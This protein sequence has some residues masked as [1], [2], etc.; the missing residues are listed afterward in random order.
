M[1]SAK[2]TTPA[3]RFKGFVEE[4]EGRPLGDIAE[5]VT[6][7]DPNSTAPVMMITADNGFIKQSD[8]YAFNNSGQS[9]TKY[10]VLKREELAY[11]HGASKLRPYGSCFALPYKEARVPFVY[12]CFTVNNDNSDFIAIQL[13]GTSVEAELRKI[14]S[15][16]ARMDG[17][18]NISYEAYS[19]AP[20][21]LP[22]TDEQVA[23]AN[24]F[25]N[26]DNLI[27]LQRR[28]LVK[29]QN[30]KKAMLQKMFPT[31][32]S[33]TPQ[34]RFAGFTD[35][36]EER[37]L[38][39][40]CSIFTDGDWIESKDQ[41]D[42]G[43]RLI[44]TGNVGVAEFIDKPNNSKWISEETFERLHCK[45]V[46]PGDILI[47]RLPEPAGRACIIPNLG[48]KM[49]TAVDCTI[50]RTT[51]DYCNEYL[52]QYLSS[53]EYFNEVNTVLAGGTRQ[54]ISRSNL[55]NFTVLVPPDYK[56]QQAIGNYF[57][58]LDTRISQQQRKLEKLQ[59]VKKACLAAMFV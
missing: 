22:N 14:V 15:S 11:N 8:R 47:S 39:S 55:A 29:L 46:L 30:V 49:I 34:I 26:L 10:I 25:N 53:Q 1:A 35:P 57:S 16:G 52:I 50:V 54:R 43:A 33:T 13:N 31:R 32:G 4:W 28:K 3:L 27:A 6:R 2:L 18:L 41:S 45:E 51:A 12:H 19:K 20:I 5:K 48:T 24:Y 38:G 7:T 9:L 23:I 36:W 17:L 40:L 37:K 44:Q 59:N 58:T 42:Y 21:S 56:E